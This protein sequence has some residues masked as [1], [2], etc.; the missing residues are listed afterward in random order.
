M[1]PGGSQA[2]LLDLER[3]QSYFSLTFQLLRQT[4][5]TWQRVV[6]DDLPRCTALMP[7]R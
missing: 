7:A 6:S 1:V 2:L 3:M 4:R 5:G